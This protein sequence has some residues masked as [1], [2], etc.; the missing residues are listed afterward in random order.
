MRAKLSVPSGGVLQLSAGEM[1]A[2]S[3]VNCAWMS[4]PGLNEDVVSCKVV[5]PRHEWS[6]RE[7]PSPTVR[8]YSCAHSRAVPV[9][10]KAQYRVA[11]QTDVECIGS[12]HD[13]VVRK[14]LPERDLQHTPVVM[15]AASGC[16]TP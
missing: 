6:G 1:S 13:V 12:L 16:A 8:A 2:P 3:H 7:W 5:R 11:E 14:A 15:E 4:D 10:W 9:A